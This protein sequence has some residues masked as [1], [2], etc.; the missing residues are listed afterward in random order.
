M[1]YKKVIIITH[2]LSTNTMTTTTTIMLTIRRS[3]CFHSI[4]TTSS[5]YSLPLAPYTTKPGAAW[6]KTYYYSL[7]QC[8]ATKTTR[9]VGSRAAT[10]Q[11]IITII[12]ITASSAILFTGPH[13]RHVGNSNGL[14]RARAGE[15]EIKYVSALHSVHFIYFIALRARLHFLL[16]K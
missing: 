14:C 9:L 8:N 6:T 13:T 16:N 15:N 1:H 4:F 5:A 7:E 3:S 11:Y 12:I 2:V 10:Q